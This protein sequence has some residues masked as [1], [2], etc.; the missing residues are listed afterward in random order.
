MED[1]FVY[2]IESEKNGRRYKGLTTDLEI[3]LKDHNS[4]KTKSTKAFCPWK[5]VYFE[6]FDSLTEARDREKYFKTAVGRRF[7]ID[8]IG[9]VVQRIPARPKERVIRSFG[10]GIGV[11]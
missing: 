4:G 10:R 1:W 11:S 8:K 9:P 6:K 7:L 3:R 2:V 5:L